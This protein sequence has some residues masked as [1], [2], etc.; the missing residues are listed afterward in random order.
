MITVVITTWQVP[1]DQTVKAVMTFTGEGEALAYVNQ[2]SAQWWA[3]ID[4]ARSMLECGDDDND[5]PYEP[6]TELGY[7]AAHYHAWGGECGFHAMLDD[8][9]YAKLHEA[10]YARE[11]DAQGLER[12]GY[13]LNAYVAGGKPGGITEAEAEK[14]SDAQARGM[15]AIE[16][17]NKPKH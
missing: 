5:W 4:G 7:D 14:Y 10:H 3:D 6:I 2:Q 17:I 12:P 16:A 11:F 9:S 13:L 8:V 15:A 1:F